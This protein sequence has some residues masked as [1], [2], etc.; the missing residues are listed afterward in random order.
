MAR[1]DVPREIVP[2]L[3]DIWVTVEIKC[4]EEEGEERGR[5][6]YMKQAESFYINPEYLA[7]TENQKIING[8]VQFVYI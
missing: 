7:F 8:S 4:R 3:C 6:S 5:G 2:P 1:L